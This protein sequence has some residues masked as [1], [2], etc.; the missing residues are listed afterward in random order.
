MFEAVTQTGEVL[1]RSSNAVKVNK[2]G[3]VTDSMESVDVDKGWS[4]SGSAGIDK[5]KNSLE[6]GSTYERGYRG[7]ASGQT[8]NIRNIDSSQEERETYS[9]TTQL[10]QVHHLLDSYHLGTNR[11]LFVILPRPRMA[12]VE[13]SVTTGPRNL[14]GIQEFFLVVEQPKDVNKL[15][16]ETQL[17][18]SHL[19]KVTHNETIGS[20]K[21]EEGQIE[22]RISDSYKGGFLSQHYTKRMYTIPVPGGF[23]VDRTKGNG[24]YD[25]NI[26]QGD[27]VT[28]DIEGS[29]LVRVYD[30]YITV[31]VT[32]DPAGAPDVAFFTAD[33]IVYYISED[34]I[35]TPEIKT[36]EQVD[37]FMT[38]RHL[39]GCLVADRQNKWVRD[40]GHVVATA[41]FNTSVVYE[42][43]VP[44]VF[45]DTLGGIIALKTDDS[46]TKSSQ[47]TLAN[48]FGTFMK[49]SMM[50]SMNSPD[51]YPMGKYTILDTDFSLRRLFTSASS[52][53][54]RPSASKLIEIPDFIES[55][56]STDKIKLSKM[57]VGDLLLTRGSDL[58]RRLD[59][60]VK[61]VMMLKKINV[62]HSLIQK[63]KD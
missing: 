46:T 30:T 8:V 52:N 28:E 15:C 24:G 33:Y 37:L 14:E 60:S 49:N 9:H 58:A 6:L 1:S 26:L 29:P 32:Y 50:S 10:S 59:I 25:E 61:D 19:N 31:E 12:D 2:G 36:V 63:N 11:A 5:A 41:D 38:G 48:E 35:E 56:S 16:I 54:F 45:W 51:R 55:I 62:D 43:G 23:K 20:T 27:D 53:R 21:Y 3:T 34:P 13:L 39:R 44:K 57:S 17:E 7:K 42:Q 22:Q 4:F 47:I 40:P 18:T